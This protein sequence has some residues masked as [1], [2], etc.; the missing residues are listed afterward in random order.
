MSTTSQQPVDN[1]EPVLD[2]L[3][4][5]VAL[6]ERVRTRYAELAELTASG[7]TCG[8]GQPVDCGCGGG[9]CTSVDGNQARRRRRVL[10]HRRA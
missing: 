7:A 3:V 10:Q 6:R 8:C 2:G 4:E 5:E 1:H 9:C